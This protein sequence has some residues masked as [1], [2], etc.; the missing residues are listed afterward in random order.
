MV[1]NLIEPRDFTTEELDKL[2]D[3]ADAIIQDPKK[4]RDVCKGYVLASLFFEPST[5]TRLSFETAMTRLGGG[6][7]G[8]ADAKV[9]STSKGES[10]VDTLRTV[11]NYADIVAMRHPKDGAALLATKYLTRMPLINAGDGAHNHPTQTL[12]DLLTIRHYKKR[13]NNLTIGV[14]GDLKFGR[15]IHSLVRAMNRYENVKFVFISPEELKMPKVFLDELPKESYRETSDLEGSIPDLDI[16]YMSR[17]QRERFV[18]EEEYVRLKD[19]FILDKEK[20]KQAKA[21]MIVMHPLP[22][23]NEIATDVD[24][25]ERAVYFKQ[26]GFGMYVRMA[27]IM[28]L[29]GLEEA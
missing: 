3:L 25:D 24:D 6:V 23:V 7:V 15:T 21:D 14:C 28:T 26:A 22:R 11:E 27:L 16:L 8:F 4:Y 12:T 1:R 10:L 17:V 20:L 13:F 9:S 5:R 29:L 18:S 19:F 2:F